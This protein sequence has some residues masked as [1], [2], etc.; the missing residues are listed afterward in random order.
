VFM[1][2]KNRPLYI[3]REKFGIE[4]ENADYKAKR[5]ASTET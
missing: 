3:I 2:T 4:I 1:E 5:N